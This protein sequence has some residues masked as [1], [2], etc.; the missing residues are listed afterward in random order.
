MKRNQRSLGE[1]YFGRFFRGTKQAASGAWRSL[2]KRVPPAL[3]LA[4]H[5]FLETF[6]PDPMPKVVTSAVTYINRF[7]YVF[8]PNGFA[9]SS[10][11][12][13]MG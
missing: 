6:L 7:L 8:F 2:W 5:I 13:S 11:A 9:L 4:K 10:L 3:L 1:R 12:L